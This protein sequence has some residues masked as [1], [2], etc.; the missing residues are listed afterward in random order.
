[1]LDMEYIRRSVSIRSVAEA[2]GLDVLDK[3]VRCWRP[4]NHEHGDRTPSVGLNLRKNA[5]RCF[6]CDVHQLSTIDLA[7]NVLGIGLLPAVQWI[8]ERFPVPTIQKG[9]HAETRSR[10]PERVRIGLSASTLEFIV[11]SGV[12][13][14]LTPAQRSLLPV[15]DSFADPGTRIAT[16]SYRGLM[17]Y[18]GIGSQS[19]IAVAFRHFK[20]LHLI[21]IQKNTRDGLCGCN[22][23]RLT[24]DD[25]EFLQF[26]NELRGRQREEIEL[27]RKLRAKARIF[28]RGTPRAITGKYSV[29]PLEHKP[30]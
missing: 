27:E 15:L 25:A 24:F 21:E 22:S 30:N 19:T 29:Q 8:A 11:R 28:R 23:Y 4:E 1:M 17:R 10:W 6:V 9:K 7:M 12:W 20:R 18:G 16:I 26:A 3:M 14:S 2:L 5:A 13:A